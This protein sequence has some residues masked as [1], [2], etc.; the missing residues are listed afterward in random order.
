M[1]GK[2]SFTTANSQLK[3]N[4]YLHA[5]FEV[6]MKKISH[7]K[8]WEITIGKENKMILIENTSTVFFLNIEDHPS[9]VDSLK[10][11]ERQKNITTYSF[12]KLDS[13]FGCCVVFK[14]RVLNAFSNES[15]NCYKITWRT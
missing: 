13:F 15:G 6:K 8:Y 5:S 14:R 3:R 12:R 1:C 7:R 4:N 11:I 2:N 10:W 9:A